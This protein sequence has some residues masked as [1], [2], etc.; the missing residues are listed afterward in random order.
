L[1]VVRPAVVQAK[2]VGPLGRGL[3]HLVGYYYSAAGQ[4]VFLSVFDP[5]KPL[6]L[7]ICYCTDVTSEPKLIWLS[8]L[9]P[10]CT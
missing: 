2:Q 7:R 8:P 5:A 6:W 1:V 3:G 4:I 10:L 9:K